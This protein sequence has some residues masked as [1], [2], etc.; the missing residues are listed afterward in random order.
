MRKFRVLIILILAITFI[1]C[2]KEKQDEIFHYYPTVNTDSVKN[3]LMYSAK[4]FGTIKESGGDSIINVGFCWSKNSNPSIN[5]SVILMSYIKNNFDAK[6]ENLTGNT[7]YYFRTIAFN[8]Y[9]TAFGNILEFKTW[10]GTLKDYDGNEY[11]GVQ[12]GNQGWMAENLKSTHYSDGTPIATWCPPNMLYWYGQDHKIM[13]NKEADMNNDGLLNSSDSL[14]YVNNYGLLYTWYAANN[15]YSTSCNGWI[16]RK[17]AEM[18]NDVCPTGWHLPS[19]DEWEELEDYLLENNGYN[20]DSV[21]IQIKSK[22][23]WNSNKNGN[24]KYGLNIL[25]AGYWHDPSLTHYKTLG[26][27]AYLWTSTEGNSSN[28]I[29][30]YVIDRLTDGLVSKSWYGFSVRCVKDE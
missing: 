23:M 24:N 9:D 5:D 13:P 19:Q 1:A 2:E 20:Y 30:I 25:P 27:G 3:V 4:L 17:V 22:T 10:D 18:C 16:D 7:N 26:Y 6:I 29:N 11:E 12:I 14:I 8:N 28:G 15:I 21:S